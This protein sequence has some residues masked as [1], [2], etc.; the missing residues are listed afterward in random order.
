[1][2]TAGRTKGPWRL[3]RDSEAPDA[4]LVC[5]AEGGSIA[6]TSPPGPWMT[7]AEAKANAAFIVQA[8]NSHDDL[9][10]A[11][12]EIR[13]MPC[14]QVNDSESLRHT[15]NTLRYI[16]TNALAAAKPTGDA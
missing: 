6:D 1:M 5:D 14:S 11:L 10:K 16:A 15:I 9:V 13:D 12:E 2:S 7:V 4:M 8:C 3:P